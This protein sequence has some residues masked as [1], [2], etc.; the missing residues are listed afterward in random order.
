MKICKKRMF[1]SSLIAQKICIVIIHIL[2]LSYSYIQSRQN[3]PEDFHA[4]Q[5][6]LHAQFGFKQASDP[7]S[8]KYLRRQFFKAGRTGSVEVFDQVYK[9]TVDQY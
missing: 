3:V 5:K 8:D 4:Y 6:L 1:L 9:K 7:Y 2:I